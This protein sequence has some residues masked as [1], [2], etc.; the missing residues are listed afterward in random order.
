MGTAPGLRHNLTGMATTVLIV[1]DHAGFRASAR[2]LL[3]ACGYE[4]VGEAADG[5]S[6]VQAAARLRPE[7]MLLDVNLPDFDGFRVAERVTA[8]P[9]APAVILVSS[10]DASDYGRRVESCGACGF[11]AKADLDPDRLA[12]LV[13]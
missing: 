1:D 2:R 6:A 12:A 7:L 10:R 8:E 11:C 3:E 9:G 13:P 5:E 4:V